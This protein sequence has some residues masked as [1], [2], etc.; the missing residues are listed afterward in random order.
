MFFLQLHKC[1]YGHHL[2]GL[3]NTAVWFSYN[4]AAQTKREKI[5]KTSDSSSEK[6]L[7]N[8][9]NAFINALSNVCVFLDITHINQRTNGPVNAHLI[10]WPSKAQKKKN[11][12]YIW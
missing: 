11:L 7:N 1:V 4:P 6:G 12:E 2:N 10:S 8:H 9:R 3:F 5:T